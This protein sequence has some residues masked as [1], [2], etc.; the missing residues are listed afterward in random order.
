MSTN[1]VISASD[2]KSNSPATSFGVLAPNGAALTPGR[3]S[4]VEV[5]KGKRKKLSL[6]FPLLISEH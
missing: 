4:V 6:L 5:E 3:G 1:S 2:S